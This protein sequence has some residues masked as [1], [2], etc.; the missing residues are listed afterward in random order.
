MNSLAVVPGGTL[1]NYSFIAGGNFTKF[2]NVS[3]PRLA[4]INC[5][6]TGCT[7]D[8]SFT[9]VTTLDGANGVVNAL[10]FVPGSTMENFSVLI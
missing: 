4:K 5:T 2:N 1:E 9:G 10:A 6:T 8:T 3:Q 7:L